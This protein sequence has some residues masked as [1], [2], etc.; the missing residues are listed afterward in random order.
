MNFVNDGAFEAALREAGLPMPSTA[1]ACSEAKAQLSQVAFR[2]LRRALDLVRIVA[3]KRTLQ[4]EHVHNLARI[5]VLLSAPVD[6][7][8][9]R[10]TQLMRG[11]EGALGHTVM[12]GSFYGSSAADD[13]SY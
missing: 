4:P 9:P 13:A 5:A 10:A 1:K 11:G 8:A 2:V 7:A 6:S 12:T 3:V